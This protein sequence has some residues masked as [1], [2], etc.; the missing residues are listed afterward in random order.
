MAKSSGGR[1]KVKEHTRKA[2]KLPPR[3]GNGQFKKRGSGKKR[4][5]VVP[6][7]TSLF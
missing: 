4:R 3:K 1:V 5:K 7:Q 6:A 2:G